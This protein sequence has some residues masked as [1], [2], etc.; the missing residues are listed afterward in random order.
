MEKLLLQ[1][2]NLCSSQ[3]EQEA[4]LPCQVNLVLALI[5]HLFLILVSDWNLSSIFGFAM[6]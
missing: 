5:F 4:G 1:E 6:S 2:E 3:E